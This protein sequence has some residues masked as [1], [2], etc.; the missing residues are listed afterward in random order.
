M[1]ETPLPLQLQALASAPPSCFSFFFFFPSPDEELRAPLPS[2]TLITGNLDNL[3]KMLKI[4][5]MRNDVMSR[6]HNA[7]YLGDVEERI[8]VLE[9]S[10]HAPLAYLTAATH[11]AH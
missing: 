7:L 5:E 9:E 1:A 4:A 6:F 8:K 3:T 2:C 10:G 11:G